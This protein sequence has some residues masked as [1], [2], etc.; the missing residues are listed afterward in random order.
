MKKTLASFLFLSLLF[1][2]SCE[3]ESEILGLIP[4]DTLGYGQINSPETIIADAEIMI[5]ELGMQGLLQ[6]KTVPDLIDQF[7]AEEGAPFSREVFDFSKPFGAALRPS[8]GSFGPNTRIFLPSKDP[9]ALLE[10]FQKENPSDSNTE[11]KISGNY[12]V[13]DPQGLGSETESL[14]VSSLPPLDQGTL[15]YYGDIQRI[16]KSIPDGEASFRTFLGEAEEEL[17]GSDFTQKQK[18]QLSIFLE[19][20]EQLW[21]IWRPFGVS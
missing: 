6:G 14:D 17:Q 16:L 3:E 7:L 20:T 1:L 13:V 8:V 2:L 4:A 19:T 12:F 9:N 21:R 15:A 11:A 5:A 10:D 18:D